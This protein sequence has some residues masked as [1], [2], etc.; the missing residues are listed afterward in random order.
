MGG[1]GGGG[2]R[3]N[4]VAVGRAVD[5]VLRA[6]GRQQLRLRGPWYISLYRPDKIN[7]GREGA[8]YSVDI[9]AVLTKIVRVS[10]TQTI[11]HKGA[12]KS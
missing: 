3:P 4:L 7:A 6:E 8:P 2:A 11:N 1:G 10:S 5:D 9:S 12:S